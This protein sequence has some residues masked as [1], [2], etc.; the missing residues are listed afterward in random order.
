M[1]GGASSSRAK[2]CAAGAN[3]ED[4]RPGGRDVASGVGVS[5]ELRVLIAAF[6]DP[7]IRSRRSRWRGAAGAGPS[8]GVRDVGEV[9]GGAGRG[10]GPSTRRRSAGVRA[11]GCRRARGR[12]CRGGACR[13]LEE[14][15]PDVVVNDILTLARRWRRR[16][17]PWATL[18]PHVFPEHAPGLPFFAFGGARLPRTPLGRRLWTP[19][20]VLEAGLRK[21]RDELNG[22]RAGWAGANGAASRRHEPGAGAGGDVPAAR[23]P[24]SGRRTC[25]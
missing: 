4:W 1:S 7:D 21:G 20:P 9:A 12:G 10:W 16:A 5:R 13:F 17:V 11:R 18:I 14:L 23:Y 6:G 24:R 22:E 15:G 3:V 8:G 25:T 2:G 19:R